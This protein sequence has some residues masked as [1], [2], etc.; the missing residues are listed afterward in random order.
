MRQVPPTGRGSHAQETWLH[1]ACWYGSDHEPAA[2]SRGLGLAAALAAPAQA[3]TVG[4]VVNVTR[5][6][7]NQAEGSIAVDP[8]DPSH[9]AAVSN[10]GD[11]AGAGM[12]AAYS[13]DHGATWTHRTITDGND[14]LAKSCCDPSLTWDSFGNL[15]LVY[16]DADTKSGAVHIVLS[17]DGGKT[18]RSRRQ[19][20]RRPGT[21]RH[22]ARLDR[23]G[24]RPPLNSASPHCTPER[25]SACLP[26]SATTSPA[27]T[28][29]PQPDTGCA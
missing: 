15:F 23:C 10:N 22:R 5:S 1:Q 19:R 2:L 25:R 21:Q 13:T 6:A 14:G 18:L 11:G 26:R 27:R 29:P 20:I 24:A 8:K 3:A 17:T 4:T 7:G 16:L 12:T 28:S 9:L